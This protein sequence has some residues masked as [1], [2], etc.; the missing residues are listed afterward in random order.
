MR[1][2][3]SPIR[4]FVRE[5]CEM[6]PDFEIEVDALYGALKIWAEN[7]GHPKKTKQVF[8]RDLRAAH[9]AIRAVQRGPFEARYRVYSG[10]RLKPKPEDCGMARPQ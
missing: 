1:D 4:A 6:G 5:E 10:I 8:G 2:L 7:N 9:S 3:A